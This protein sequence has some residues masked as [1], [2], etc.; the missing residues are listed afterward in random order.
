MKPRRTLRSEEALEIKLELPLL[1]VAEL[2]PDMA[3]RTQVC[4]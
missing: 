2:V 4:K 3:S 1:A